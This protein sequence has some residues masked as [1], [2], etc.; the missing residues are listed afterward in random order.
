MVQ[1]YAYEVV[2]SPG[3]CRV[4]EVYSDGGEFV[5]ASVYDQ[6]LVPWDPVDVATDIARLLDDL[7]PSFAGVLV[8]KAR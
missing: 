1:P 3:G 6:D 4:V 5:V 2:Q 7:K 8:R